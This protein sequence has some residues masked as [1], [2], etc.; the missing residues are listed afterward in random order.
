MLKWIIWNR[1]DYLYKN[2]SDIEWP[3]KVDVPWNPTN[4]PTKILRIGESKNL[5]QQNLTVLLYL[6]P[7]AVLE[8][9]NWILFAGVRPPPK[10]Y[11][12]NMTASSDKALIT[13]LWETWCAL[14]LPLLPGSHWS[15]VVIPELC[16]K[17]NKWI[18]LEPSLK[19]EQ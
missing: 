12:L 9:A 16:L 2:G 5:I 13:E 11:V 14:N 19:I 17:I 10:G 15:R 3:T 1:T 4:Q 18:N 8:F 7:S 6:M